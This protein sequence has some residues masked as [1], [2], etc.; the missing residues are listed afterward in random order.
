[1]KKIVSCFLAFF[2][3][4][5]H[6]PAQHQQRIDSLENAYRNA[7]VDT[8][9]FHLLS[10]L[11]NLY[12]I[13]DG[14]K[15]LERSR[16][17]LEMA[18][19]L[20]QPRFR[21]RA[22]FNLAVSLRKTGDY[23]TAISHYQ[24]ALDFFAEAKDE[25][26]IGMING[27]LGI[28]YWQRDE[29]DKA[30]EHMRKALA[31]A[32]RLGHTE[33]VCANL[34]NIGGVFMKQEKYD[35]A[36]VYLEKTRVLYAQMK[37]TA[38]L[39]DAYGNMGAI[40]IELK[41]TAAARRHA[42]IGIDYAQRSD[43]HYQLMT[44]Y[45]TLGGV[46]F[47]QQRYP[48]AVSYFEKSIAIAT[49]LESKESLRDSYKSLSEI[50]S[51]AGRHDSAFKYLALYGAVKDS[52]L[53]EA[54]LRQINEMEAKYQSVKTAQ[55]LVEQ[56]AVN[57]RKTLWLGF[58]LSG[59][60]LVLILA[61]F[62]WRGYVNKRKAGKEIQ[63]QKEVIEEKNK[64]ILDSIH[65]AERIQQ[66]LLPSDSLR[67]QLLPES[68]VFYRPKAIV[69]GDFYW[70]AESGERLLFAVGDCTGHGV[71]GSLMS[72][73]CTNALNRAV[74]EFGIAAP[75]S[76]LDKV[77]ELVQESFGGSDDRL[78]DHSSGTG[79]QDGMDISLCCLDRKTGGLQWAGANN[80]LWLVRNGEL[81]EIKGDKQPIGKFIHA[82][83]FSTHS[84]E[85]R[86]GDLLYLFTDGFADQFGGPEGKKFK[87]KQ[88]AQLLLLHWNNDLQQQ[89]VL[90]ERRFEEWRGQL[91][92]IDDVC[93][94]G[95]RI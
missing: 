42:L 31:V 79:V 5:P 75:G 47:L 83:P 67:K 54:K 64:E 76:I 57:E 14:K 82:R 93:V 88:L 61:F 78:N 6:L 30:L 49:M 25:P 21:G 27:S 13:S 51:Q 12:R 4:A 37:D 46:Y 87:Y 53:S 45:G 41:D 95:V 36:L 66:A 11:I 19:N 8:A 40:Y 52:L 86:K 10:E 22:H 24:K 90:I 92:Q 62:I 48:E 18:E 16:L 34:N 58:A 74:K 70:L 33:R 1:M 68:F 59:F 2:F 38:G 80:P 65:Y 3:F 56:K 15:A 35:S 43:Y 17:Q 9:A 72:V 73:V 63:L 39:A 84:I 44:S 50:Y 29:F 20:P 32:E 89:A 69:A 55:E 28:T 91:E 94:M 71:P 85:L 7:T 26:N 60:V 81:I 23:E 77:R